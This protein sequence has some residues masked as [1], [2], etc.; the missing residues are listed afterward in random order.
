MSFLLLVSCGGKD[1]DPYPNSLVVARVGDRV[2]T[3]S[4]FIRRVEYTPRPAYCRGDNNIHKKIVLN[5]LIAEKLLALD[6]LSKPEYESP[7]H[8]D[9]YIL[10]RREQ[11]M[12]QLYR[13]DYGIN[14]V[15]TTDEELRNNFL[16]AR[17][18]YELG[19]VTFPDSHYAYGAKEFL[20]QGVSFEAIYSR[21]LG[22]E[23]MDIRKVTWFDDDE[24]IIRNTL[25]SQPLERGSVLG[26]LKLQDGKYLMFKVIA[27]KDNIQLSETGNQT[28]WDDVVSKVEE[29]KGNQLYNDH[30]SGLMRGKSFMLEEA[31]FRN[32][33]DDLAEKYLLKEA[34]K[35]SMLNQAIWEIEK[36]HLSI[37]NSEFEVSYLDQKLFR[38]DEKD[39][40]V[41]DLTDLVSRHPLVFREKRFEM[42]DFANQVKLAIADLLRDYIVTGE[43]YDG[44]YA[45]R[46]E[47]KS[48]GEMWQDQYLSGIYKEIINYSISDSMLQSSNSIPFIERHMNPI[49]DSLQQAYSDEIFI[50]FKTFEDI[51]LTRIDMFVAQDKVPYP[52]VVPPFPQV[53]TDHIFDYGNKLESK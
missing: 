5:S 30:V 26:P 17:R 18:E 40:T 45:D 4:E 50:N 46:K 35:G 1:T 7:R 51:T 14:R 8:L 23:E 21:I 22:T 15:S 52:V 33:V 47:I 19:F 13:Y 53:T 27:W 37:N 9:Q 20:D 24:S 6:I 2:I 28:L 39:W 38:F 12:R 43:A 31:T 44:G 29:R 48:Y 42:A 25:Y 36:Q 3:K 41:Q 49:V 16:S 10:G 11:A 34:E 32:L